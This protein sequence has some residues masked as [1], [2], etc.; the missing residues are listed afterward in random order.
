MNS[1]PHA[2]LLSVSRLESGYGP[3][4]VIWNLSLQ[5]WSGELVALL[6]PNGAGKTTA[7]RTIAGLMKP[8]A[9]AVTFRGAGIAN[10][11]AHEISRLGIRFIPE[12]L[13]L[14][15][16]MAIEENLLLGPYTVRDSRQVREN[17]DRVFAIFP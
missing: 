6:G 17:L 5:V 1:G 12:T 9:G 10:R 7:L 11:P 16:G 15:S 14:F 13:K 3:L 2:A 4:Q 8:M